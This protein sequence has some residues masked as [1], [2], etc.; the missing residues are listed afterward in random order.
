MADI[1][2]KLLQ[3]F[4]DNLEARVIAHDGEGRTG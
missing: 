4:V 2:G 3:Q 1:T